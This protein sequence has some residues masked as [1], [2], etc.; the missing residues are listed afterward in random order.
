MRARDRDDTITD[1][2]G[3][4]V[5]HG[6]LNQ[7]IYLMSLDEADP[8]SVLPAMEALAREKGYTKIFAKVPESQGTRFRL[9]GY[10]AEARVPGF[11]NGVEAAVFFCRYFLEERE[12]AADRADIDR[13]RQIAEER[14]RAGP[15]ALTDDEGIRIRPCV[16]ADIPAMSALYRETFASYPFPIHD[17][18]YLAETMASHV[19]YFLAERDGEMVALSSAEMDRSAANVEMT[20]FATRPSWRGRRLAMRLLLR[21]EQEMRKERM[22][23]AYTIARAVSFPMNITFAALGYEHGGTLI[24]NTNISGRIESMAVWHKDLCRAGAKTSKAP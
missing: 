13:C 2:L 16:E 22:C 21:M 1:L 9:S 3:A 8:A 6:P 23:T 19:I 5:Q 7:R 4:T 15:P 14:R 10:R 18:G 20:D 24:N 11:F 12:T 17:P